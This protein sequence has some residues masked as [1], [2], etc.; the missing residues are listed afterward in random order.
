V[1]RQSWATLAARQPQRQLPKALRA[2]KAGDQ[3]ATNLCL[4]RPLSSGAMGSVWVA[5]HLTLK[6][7]VAVKFISDDIA[8]DSPEVLERFQREA[9][10]AAQI[11]S[12][13]I[14][15]TFDQGF[16]DDDTPFIVMELLEGEDLGDRLE[17]DERLSMAQTAQVLVQVSK[18]L[19]RAHAIG[20]V[21]RDIKPENIFLCDADDGMFVKI[22]DFGIAKAAELPKMG[23]TTP[24]RMIGT[25]EFMSPEMLSTTK[26]V[27]ARADL[28]ALAV[29][30]Y[31]CLT[32]EIPFFGETVPMLCIEIIGGK[33]AL[34]T[35]LNDELPLEI[36]E[37]FVKAL[38]RNPE[39]RFQ[40]AKDMARAF[41]ALVK[42][43][44]RDSNLEISTGSFSLPSSMRN[45]NIKERF[46][47]VSTPAVRSGSMLDLDHDA[48]LAA[49]ATRSE[50]DTVA[51]PEVDGG[52]T[53][54]EPASSGRGSK[55][56][57]GNHRETFSGSSAAA[58]LPKRGGV[59]K[60]L[61]ALVGL[62]AV[63]GGAGFLVTKYVDPAL[64]PGMHD[65]VVAGT[66]VATAT[67]ASD[68][69]APVEEPVVDEPTPEEPD[70]DPDET[71][72]VEDGAGG[73]DASPDA[74]ASAA[75]DASASAAP[76]PPRP[77]YARPPR[78]K[79]KKKPKPAATGLGF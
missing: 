70:V 15:Q 26:E 4:K 65:A 49:A 31:L 46:G 11:K 62:A 54:D 38:S 32:G 61:A 64:V 25:P 69:P 20:I 34:A 50:A 79:K 28:W 21:H 8:H 22:L 51:P 17:R 56:K 63:L 16:T 57:R 23:L 67:A 68:T 43:S 48:A 45:L 78:V 47:D 19:G 3:I 12:P 53:E 9:T 73:A 60:K 1:S 2:L 42:A 77:R 7:E 37:F 75:P 30:A 18:G 44:D 66:P 59:G 72:L 52:R 29:V 35:E 5:D 40:T 58:E 74:S 41:T 24:G 27:D 14:V 36:N 10:M 76:P 13:H 71:D 39:D 33:F 6:T 55:K